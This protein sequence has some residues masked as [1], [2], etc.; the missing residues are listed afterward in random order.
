MPIDEPVTYDARET[1]R[2]G[3]KSQ[4]ELTV[5]TAGAPPDA[6]PLIE[7]AGLFVIVTAEQL[8]SGNG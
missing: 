3:R 8:G 5:H 4:V 2:E 6:P 1:S 7:A